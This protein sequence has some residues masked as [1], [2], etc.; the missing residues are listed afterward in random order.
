M[1]LAS[2]ILLLA[3]CGCAAL[4]G[5]AQGSVTLE[6]NHSPSTEAVGYHIY[7]G[8]HG[9]ARRVINVGYVTNVVV[10]GLDLATT[11][12][13]YAT[14]YDSSGVESDFSNEVTH[15]TPSNTALPLLSVSVE[16]FKIE[17]AALASVGYNLQ[18]STNFSN[19]TTYASFLSGT[20]TTARYL[21]TNDAP[22]KYWR[23]KL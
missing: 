15:T 11:Y 23:L 6:W 2:I 14:A 7:F 21:V 16:R 17:W 20:N 12:Y 9:V 13:F 8:Q 3:L 10:T 19:W 5:M 1:R 18:W 22:R 4:S